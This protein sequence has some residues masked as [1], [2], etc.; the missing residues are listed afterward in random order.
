MQKEI[1][2]AIR[3]RLNHNLSQ[4]ELSE[5]IG[6]VRGA[7]SLFERGVNSQGEPVSE[8]AWQ[9]YKMACAGVQRELE[10]GRGFDW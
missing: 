2:R 9:R 10:T 5:R 6:W 8:Y 7:V 4:D 3:W 1:D